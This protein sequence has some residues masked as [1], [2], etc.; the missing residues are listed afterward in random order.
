MSTIIVDDFGKTSVDRAVLLLAGIGGGVEKAVKS[1]M[2]RAVSALRSKTSE[3][4]REKYAISAANIRTQQNTKVSYTYQNGV[5]AAVTFGGQ[6]IPLY[7]YDG[8]APKQPTVDI[9]KLVNARIRGNWVSVHP[10][11]AASGHQLLDTAPTTFNNAFVARM[12]SGHVGIFERTGGVTAD[13]SDE[14]KE[15]MGSSVP[16]MLGS[17]EIEERLAEVA[18]EKFEERMEH[19][20][21]RLLAGIGV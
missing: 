4:I 20:I 11:V 13:G 18:K 1:A 14:I 21:N 9:N 6:K 19:E 16:Q 8:A 5:T 15:L 10:G 2:P 17:K 7:R 12:K 3:K